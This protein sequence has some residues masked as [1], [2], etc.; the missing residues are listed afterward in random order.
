MTALFSILLVTAALAKQHSVALVDRVEG[1]ATLQRSSAAKGR[2]ITKSRLISLY[3]GDRIEVTEGKIVIGFFDNDR[4]QEL[5]PGSYEVEEKGCRAKNAES[6]IHELSTPKALQPPAAKEGWDALREGSGQGAGV[7]VRGGETTDGPPPQVVPIHGEAILTD[8]PHFSWP[9]DKK[10]KSYKVRLM[11]AGSSRL[12]WS[13]TSDRVELDY[14][15]GEPP[16]KRNRKY[17]W[18]VTPV[19]DDNQFPAPLCSSDFIVDREW[20]DDDVK[21]LQESAESREPWKVLLAISTYQSFG[22]EQPA[23]AA[24]RRLV[25]LVPDDAEVWRLLGANLARAGRQAE[26]D[27]A[28]KKADSLADEMDTEKDGP[29]NP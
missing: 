5:G 19:L 20:D 27:E 21:Q 24:S 8:R 1:Q 9:A 16:L 15:E 28:R 26:A 7:I 22:L 12:I 3:A 23:L 17:V 2:P 14:P 18:Q 11:A 6:R 10:A 13:A 4:W 25:E 29:P